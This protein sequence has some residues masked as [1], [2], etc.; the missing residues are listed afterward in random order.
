MSVRYQLAKMVL[1]SSAAIE[2][3]KAEYEALIGAVKKLLS[4]L[5]AEEKFD[6]L[7]ENY[8]DLEKYILDQAFQALFVSRE[9]DDVAWQ[10]P[11]NTT[12]RKLA[13]LLSS[14]RL[15][16]DTLGRH[17]TTITGDDAAADKIK[18]AKRAQFDS[19]LSYRTLDALRNYAQHHALPVH[20][21]SVKGAW[22]KDRK[23]SEHEFAPMISISEVAADPEFKPSTLAEL[24]AGP[25]EVELK[26][27]VRE[28]VEA[29]ST[30]HHHFRESTKWATDEQL[31]IIMEAKARFFAALPDERDIGVAV[32]L[33]DEHGI[34]IGEATPISE[35]MGKYLDF[36]QRKNMHLV[37]FARRRIKY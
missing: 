32:F 6:C 31:R 9:L 21:F 36:L 26:P 2:L 5:D 33:A 10:A 34:L 17:A 12:A 3:S 4:C 27:M 19:S 1:S 23:F 20:G 28:Y 24:K 7:I 18:A 15:Y 13:N 11:R 16:Q 35:A 22:T 30:I 14:V 25:A 8:R 29:L 37:N